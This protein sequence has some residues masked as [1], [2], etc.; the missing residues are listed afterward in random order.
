MICF[1]LTG[2]KDKHNFLLWWVKK[3][4]KNGSFCKIRKTHRKGKIRMSC[5][6]FKKIC[7]HCRWQ[8]L[9]LEKIFF[10]T[11]KCAYCLAFFLIDFMLFV[12]AHT[13]NVK[14]WW[15]ISY[16]V[17]HVVV[18]FFQLQAFKQVLNEKGKRRMMET[19]T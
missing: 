3:L 13:Q 14:I 18:C 2:F 8:T 15:Y 16:V 10:K 7:N 11:H 6:M 19:L 5:Q 4:P 1:L 17:F 9:I 12:K